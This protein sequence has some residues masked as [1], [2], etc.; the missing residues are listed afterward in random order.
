MCRQLYAVYIDCSSK[1]QSVSTVDEVT[2][3]LCCLL[4]SMVLPIL[5]HNSQPYNRS[6]YIIL[7]LQSYAM[8]QNGAAMHS[9]NINK[10]KFGLITDWFSDT[11]NKIN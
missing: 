6:Y 9:T 5:W 10:I 7:Y 1:K 3:Y 11:V 4:N 2:R 8:I